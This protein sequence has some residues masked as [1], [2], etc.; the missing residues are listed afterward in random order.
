VTLPLGEAL[1][2]AARQAARRHGTPLYL[3]ELDRLRADV[4]DLRTAFPEPWLALYALKAN[5]LPA[6]IRELP[7]LGFGATA[8]SGGELALAG[9]ARF[10]EGSTALEGIGKRPADLARV[11]ALAAAG[12]PLLWTSLETAAEAAE[13]ATLVRA[14]RAGASGA[15][16][17]R[18]DVLVRINPQVRPET[19][20][21]LAVGAAGSKFGVLVEELPDVVAAGGGPEGPLRWRGVHVHVGSQLGAVDAWRS[22]FRV[23]LAVLGLQRAALPDF[24]T[25]DAGSG[26]PVGDADDDSLPTL[27]HFARA[28]AEALDELPEGARPARL[29]IEPGR[30]IV[31]R[32]GWLVARVLHVRE[33]EPRQV[34]LDAGMTE[35][36]RPAL[37]GARHPLA[38]LTSLGHPTDGTEPPTHVVVDGP[39]CESTDRLGMAELPALRRG[40]L[41]A[42]G[43]AGAY[44][45][46]MSST[47]NGRPRAP[48]L[49]WDGGRL[50]VLRRRGRE[51][52]LP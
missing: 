34:V 27:G 23:G 49:A 28:A 50:R 45:S 25:L 12:R 39:I 8:V 40:D 33:R 51:A 41:V 5:G 46:S 47:Y 1:A 52:G 18:L 19:E 38:A 10:A 42:V 16:R 6:L 37:Y 21:G 20:A 13:L 3:Y 30:A 14:A 43:L 2:D 36:I 7:S 15:R 29:A 48:E 11:V 44:A 24:D 22:A 9:R 26:F 32:C 17:L 35:L 31:A 4:R